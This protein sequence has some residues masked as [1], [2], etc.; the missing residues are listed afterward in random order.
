V[1]EDWPSI[2]KVRYAMADLLYFQKNWDECGPAFDAVVAEDPNGPNAAE[3]AFA[4][5]LCYQNIYAKTHADGSHRQTG[6]HLADDASKDGA[7]DGKGKGKGKGKEDDGSKMKPKEFNASQRG[8]ITA[9]DRYICYIKPPENDA[10]AL[11]QYVEI[12]YARA[13]TYYEAQHWQEAAEAFREIA[14]SHPK[15]EAGLYAAQL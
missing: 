1:K 14:L 5:V 4:S 13:R 12:K 3:A 11:E 8:M 2:A 10:E 9:F 6:G 7:K 15:L